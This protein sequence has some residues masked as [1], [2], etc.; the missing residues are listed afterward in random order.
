[1]GSKVATQLTRRSANWLR[2]GIGSEPVYVLDLGDRVLFLGFNR[3]CAR[4]SGV[5]LEQ[6]FAQLVTVREGLV[7]HDEVWFRWEEG[8][9]A[10][11][12]DPDAIALPKRESA[13]QV[14]TGSSP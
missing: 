7:T 4:T 13:G 3:M 5:Q 9:R 12:L 8:L 10:A 2:F 14:A 6:E 11:G 1:V